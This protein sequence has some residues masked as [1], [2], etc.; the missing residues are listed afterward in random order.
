[1]KNWVKIP[2]QDY[3]LFNWFNPENK[4]S[5]DIRKIDEIYQVIIFNHRTVKSEW[6]DFKTEKEAITFARKYMRSNKK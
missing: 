1:M 4:L 3:H 6:N 5:L 2:R